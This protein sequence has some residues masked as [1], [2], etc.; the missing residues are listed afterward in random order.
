MHRVSNGGLSGQPTMHTGLPA[1]SRGSQR[2]EE[3][4]PRASC[5]WMEEAGSNSACPPPAFWASPLPAP[6]LSLSCCLFQKTA[7]DAP[8]RTKPLPLLP[9]PASA[10][11]SRPSLCWNPRCHLCVAAIGLVAL[12]TILQQS[13][14]SAS[15]LPGTLIAPL[16][17]FLPA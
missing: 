2:G 16:T 12:R 3:T 8:F 7:H 9:L 6:R 1:I 17:A 14:L 15:A 13:L 10:P 4:C 11:F 5:L